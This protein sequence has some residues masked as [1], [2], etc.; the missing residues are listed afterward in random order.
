MLTYGYERSDFSNELVNN[1]KN[2]AI[3]VEVMKLIKILLLLTGEKRALLW[4]KQSSRFQAFDT[5]R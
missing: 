5:S 4:F 1:M 3:E 2:K